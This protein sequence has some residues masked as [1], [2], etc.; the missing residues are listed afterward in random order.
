[1]THLER[2]LELKSLEA[3]DEFRMNTVTQ[4]LQTEGKKDNAGKLNGD[5]KNSN[6]NNKNDRKSKTVFLPFGTCGNANHLT[7]ECNYGTNAA[8]R[9]LPWKNKPA[10]QNGPQLE[11]EQDNLTENVQAAAQAL[12]SICHVLTLE[13][14]VTDWRLLNSKHFH[15]SL[16]LP[17]STL[18]R[19]SW[20]VSS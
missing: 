12:N 8:N 3:P 7:E 4:K 16:M 15:L 2:E 9:P 6:P 11:D 10:G 14:N 5:T 18:Q 13:L 17:G 20:T 19:Y 1:M